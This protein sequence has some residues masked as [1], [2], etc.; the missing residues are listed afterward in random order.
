MN[1]EH[2]IWVHESAFLQMGTEPRLRQACIDFCETKTKSIF[3]LEN[4]K[5]QR[6]SWPHDEPTMSVKNYWKKNSF[7]KVRKGGVLGIH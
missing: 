7:R 3:P 1:I 5:Q 4:D 6:R 2:M